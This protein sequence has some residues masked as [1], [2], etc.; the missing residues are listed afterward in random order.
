MDKKNPDPLQ[1]PISPE[2]IQRMNAQSD[3]LREIGE[4]SDLEDS[5]LIV[6]FENP[7]TLPSKFLRDFKN[8]QRG[9]II[10]LAAERGVS[11]RDMALMLRTSLAQPKNTRH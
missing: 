9:F 5:Y 7:E 8:A 4:Q 3:R 6:S 10:A 1:I 2:D 11:P